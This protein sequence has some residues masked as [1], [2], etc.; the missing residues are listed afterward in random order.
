MVCAAVTI[1]LLVSCSETTGL[2][3]GDGFYAGMPT[4]CAGLCVHGKCE[5]KYNM[6]T[7]RSV[8]RQLTDETH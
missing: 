8:T 1:V 5:M 7:C 2:D 3:H 6:A 4:P